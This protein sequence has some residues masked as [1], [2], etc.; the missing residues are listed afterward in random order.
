MIRISF[1]PQPAPPPT[2]TPGSGMAA[3]S[4]RVHGPGWDATRD[5]YWHDPPLWR[6][7]RCFWCRRAD[8]RYGRRRWATSHRLQLNH[9]T[10][11]WSD[12]TG[13][14][15]LFVPDSVWF[16]AYRRACNEI[17][18]GNPMTIIVNRL[19]EAYADGRLDPMPGGPRF[20]VAP[21]APEAEGRTRRAR[22]HPTRLA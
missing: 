21:L 1:G 8:H 15:P 2:R 12:D 19:L 13:R 3:W 4:A 9:L 22:P 7:T 14:C 16:P 18:R 17:Q 6:R 10:Y 5:R 20:G 11:V